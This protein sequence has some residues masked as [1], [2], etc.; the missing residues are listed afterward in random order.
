M[1]GLGKLSP[2]AHSFLLPYGFNYNYNATIIPKRSFS[3]NEAFII[4]FV[5]R[6]DVYTKGLDLLMAAFE[7]FQKKQ[8]A[9]RLWIIGDGEGKAYLENFIKEKKLNN[10]IL[11][12]KKFG[13]EKDELISQMHLFSHPSR[14][15]G[16]PTAVLEAAVF[17]VPVIVTQATNVAEYVS[18]F[19]CG[20]A[21]ADNNVAELVRAMQQI[22]DDYASTDKVVLYAEGAKKMLSEM[23]SWHI[24]VD[25]Y[26]DLYQ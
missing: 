19:G 16:L 4:G 11:W 12:G 9:A 2:T 15:E 5:G 7:T 26:D 14:N 22:Y 20:I 3:E 21:V 13:Q 1:K 24:L 8:P 23:F 10:V 18:H 6:L 25:K 17:G